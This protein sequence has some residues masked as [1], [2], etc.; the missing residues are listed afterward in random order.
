MTSEKRLYPDKFIRSYLS[1]EK[2]KSLRL[3]MIRPNF[4]IT[5]INRYFVY[6][7]CFRVYFGGDAEAYLSS[8]DQRLTEAHE[9]MIY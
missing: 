8:Y 5:E 3:R 9:V 1:L 7:F 6:T 2:T 4:R